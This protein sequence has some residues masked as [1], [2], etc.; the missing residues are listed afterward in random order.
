MI[1]G[2]SIRSRL[3]KRDGITLYSQVLQGEEKQLFG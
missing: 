3:K 1:K 2:V